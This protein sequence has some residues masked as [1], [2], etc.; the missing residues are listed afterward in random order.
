MRG[1]GPKEVDLRGTRSPV[2]RDQE[3]VVDRQRDSAAPRFP[4]L[5]RQPYRGLR[6]MVDD[7][8]RTAHRRCI[9]Q[10]LGS[11]NSA[12]IE[13]FSARHPAERSDGMACSSWAGSGL[14]EQVR[15]VPGG[16]Q[17]GRSWGLF[18]RD[19]PLGEI[20]VIVHLPRALGL[21]RASSSGSPGMTR[22]MALRSGG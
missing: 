2:G 18:Q 21:A 9:P 19:Q 14:G 3:H 4:R 22:W 20:R 10:T 1:L 8:H 17:V 7:A 13:V 11:R 12:R 15:G 5:L 16:Q 6:V